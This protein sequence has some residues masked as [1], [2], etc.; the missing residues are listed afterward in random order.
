MGIPC[1]LVT[2]MASAES[3][4]TLAAM[5]R[6]TH[7]VSNPNQELAAQ[8]F[9]NLACALFNSMPVCSVLA[10]STLN[11]A[12][13]SQTRFSLV[14]Q[15]LLI[16]VAMVFAE[17][18]IA[19]IPN[20][21]LAGIML[22]LAYNLGKPSWLLF[23]ATKIK[24]LP[25]CITFGAI[26][27]ADLMTGVLLGTLTS[28]T[29]GFMRYGTTPFRISPVDVIRV[30]HEPGT[31]APYPVRIVHLFRCDGPAHAGSIVGVNRFRKFLKKGVKEGSIK[32]GDHIVLDFKGVEHVDL[33]GA[34]QMV[35]VA[36]YISSHG[37]GL[38]IINAN[39]ELQQKSK[40]FEWNSLISKALSPSST[41]PPNLLT[42]LTNGQ[43]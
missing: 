23:R 8:G 35:F 34:E 39:S 38:T 10:R 18:L 20:V 7:L 3:L 15:S 25:W 14:L 36:Y 33:S 1:M 6:Q 19:A 11:M 29:L 43:K 40:L 27:A 26:L 9:A 31:E 13:G 42:A 4:L 22:N 2:M 16:G 17:P 5:E 21:A 37:I 12:A 32:E 24:I 30:P 28:Y 41:V